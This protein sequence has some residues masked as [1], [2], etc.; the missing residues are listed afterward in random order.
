MEHAKDIRL[1][2]NQL[3]MHFNS[4]IH[5]DVI[6]LIVSDSIIEGG[7]RLDCSGRGHAKNS[8][9]GAGNRTV[10]SGAHHGGFGGGITDLQNSIGKVTP[11]CL[12]YSYLVMLIP[13]VYCTVT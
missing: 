8:G 9:P 13:T 12:L 1:H 2:V 11:H 7:A 5:A 3:H 6:D 4:L 10:G